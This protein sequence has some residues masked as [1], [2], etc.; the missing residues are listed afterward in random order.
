MLL[1]YKIVTALL[2]PAGFTILCL[3]CG[4]ILRR[5][6]F[7]WLG[8][9]ALLLFSMPVASDALMRV[10]EGQSGRVPV[11]SISKA[12]AIVVLSG[13]IEP[14]EGAPLGEWGDAVDRF[15]GGIELFRAGKA[16]AIVFTRGQLPWKPDLIPEGEL[17]SKRALLLQLP[18]KSIRLTAKAGNTADEALATARLL[19]VGKGAGKK[20]ILVTSAYHMRRS[21]LLFE[22]AG[23]DVVPFR[24]DFQVF[25]KS[26]LTVLHF[27]PSAGA[28]VQSEKALHELVGWLFYWGKSQLG[29]GERV[30]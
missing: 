2:M 4:L 12:D 29:L 26:R 9:L 1:L 8:F 21:L 19:G 13:M 16:P 17:L 7:L 30:V 24:V 22:K 15:E 27:L 3:L 20:I 5:R 10:L 14:V 6:F 23:F 25:D 28:L 11:S 18:T